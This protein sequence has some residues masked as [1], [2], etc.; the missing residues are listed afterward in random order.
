MKP[1]A[2]L[3]RTMEHKAMR[4][5][6]PTFH[7]ISISLNISITSLKI[8]ANNKINRIH[9]TSKIYNRYFIDNLAKREK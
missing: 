1:H 8:H 6:D 9:V 2:H 3:K 4:G 7:K 5:F